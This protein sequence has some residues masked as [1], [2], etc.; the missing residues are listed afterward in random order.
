MCVN[1]ISMHI[2]IL[3]MLPDFIALGCLYYFVFLPRWK[4]LSKKKFIWY[5]ALYL[6]ICVMMMLTLMPIIIHI[7]NIFNGFSSETN[8]Y[9]FIDWQLQRGDY[10]TESLLNISL[11]IPFGFL[12]R[13]NTKFKPWQ[14]ILIG[15]FSS[16]SIEVLQP[17]LSFDRVSDVSDV[18]TN[19]IGTC[20]GVYFYQLYLRKMKL[21]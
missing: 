14:V 8:F 13:Q 21:K 18:I 9:P 10:L 4:Q 17:L 3:P 11:F 15:L 2:K 19:T 12:I 6:Y 1:I 5:T 20:I 7:P 16:I